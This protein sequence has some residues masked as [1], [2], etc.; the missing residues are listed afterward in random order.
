[1]AVLLRIDR[2]EPVLKVMCLM[3]PIQAM[4]VVAESLLQRELKFGRVAFAEL[5]SVGLGYG[6]TG[7]AMALAGFGVWSLAGAHMGHA[8]VRTVLLFAA[9]PHPLL[10]SADRRAARELVYFGAGMTGGRLA[11][12]MAAEADNLVVG[13]WLGAAALGI[14]GRARQITVSPV[15][16]FSQARDK[17]LFPA[18]AMMQSEPDRL[19]NAY[20][21]GVTLSTVVLLPASL[22]IFV[23]M[24]ELVALLL[25]PGW[26]GVVLPGRILAMG[27]LLQSGHRLSDSLIRGSGRVYRGAWRHGLHAVLVTAGALVGQQWGIA[28][29]AVG[30]LAALAIHYLVMGQFCLHISGGK[31]RDFWAAHLPGLELA[32][33]VGLAAWAAAGLLRNRHLPPALVLPGTL[34]AVGLALLPALYKPRLLLGEDGGRAIDHLRS[35]L[36]AGGNLLPRRRRAADAGSADRLGRTDVPGDPPV[37]ASIQTSHDDSE[38]V[39]GRESHVYDLA[40]SDTGRVCQGS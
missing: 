6:V 34:A 16:V 24:P 40:A 9:R 39:P 27:I 5:A 10:P 17:V 26:S 35:R 36:R 2:L 31:W 18:M 8:I 37:R 14:Y 11:A 20:R 32:A 21:R 25:G 1:M 7:I 29:A 22:A 3:F 30:V 12:Y 38:T 23:L 13:R 15:V 28:G 33:L 19:D 4:S